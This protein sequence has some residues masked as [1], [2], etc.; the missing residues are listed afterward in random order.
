VLTVHPARR[1]F[2][3]DFIASGSCTTICNRFYFNRLLLFPARRSMLPSGVGT[4]ANQMPA[5][6]ISRSFFEDLRRRFAS[7]RRP[8][9]LA[10]VSG[11]DMG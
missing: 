1:P 4:A 6:L 9:G 3:L 2:A 11:A 8:A 5:G 7:V 10:G